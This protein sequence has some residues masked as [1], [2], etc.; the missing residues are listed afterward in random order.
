MLR[1]TSGSAGVPGTGM[2]IVLTLRTLEFCTTGGGLVLT[3]GPVGLMAKPAHIGKARKD[4]NGVVG[5]ACVGI[6]VL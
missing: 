6:R 3:Q 4:P 2:V 5:G 1:V